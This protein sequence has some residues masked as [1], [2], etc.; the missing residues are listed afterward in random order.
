MQQA[1]CKYSFIDL[2]INFFFILSNYLNR[3]RDTP[4]KSIM[5]CCI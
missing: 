5:N 1:M 2:G 4:S 3:K